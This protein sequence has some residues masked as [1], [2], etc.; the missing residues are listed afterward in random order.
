MTRSHLARHQPVTPAD[1]D[2]LARMA[3]AAWHRAGKALIDPASL[4]DD[5]ERQTV[6]TIAERLFGRRQP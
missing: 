4:S 1:D 5:W 3:R 6:I 2:D